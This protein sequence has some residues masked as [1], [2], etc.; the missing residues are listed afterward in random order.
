MKK[1][2]F[3]TASISAPFLL[4]I[5][6]V[7]KKKKNNNNKCQLP[8]ELV[9]SEYAKLHELKGEKNKVNMINFLQHFRRRVSVSFII[10]TDGGSQSKRA[11]KIPRNPLTKKSSSFIT[12]KTNIDV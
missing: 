2:P 9:C 5:L 7:R 6:I 11:K 8:C 4:R 1:L 12:I 3:Y 10:C